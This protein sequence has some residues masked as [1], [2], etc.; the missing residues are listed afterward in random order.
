MTAVTFCDRH[1]C[2]KEIP[3]ERAINKYNHFPARYCS[4]RCRIAAAV[5]R[6][7]ARRK[8]EKEAVN[9]NSQVQ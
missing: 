2:G 1:G 9:G 4:D 5:A 6:L 3:P 8:A 7:R